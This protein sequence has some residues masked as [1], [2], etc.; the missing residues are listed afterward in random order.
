MVWGTDLR[1]EPRRSDRAY[2]NGVHAKKGV[3][4]SRVNRPL[5]DRAGLDRLWCLLRGLCIFCILNFPL[6]DAVQGEDQC[7]RKSL[8]DHHPSSVLRE[9]TGDGSTF[10]DMFTFGKS[11]NFDPPPTLVGSGI[12]AAHARASPVVFRLTS[13]GRAE[14]YQDAAERVIVGE[15]LGGCIMAH[16]VRE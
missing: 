4:D 7:A 2:R 11:V 14:E 9:E 8:Q 10:D 1:P 13:G 15:D 12:R 6:P 3:A 16:R 5:G